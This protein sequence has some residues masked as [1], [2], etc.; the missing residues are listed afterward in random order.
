LSPQAVPGI[1][2]GTPMNFID[3]QETLRQLSRQNPAEA[4]NRQI[5]RSYE[6][7]H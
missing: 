3:A 4:Q 2:T 7:V 6:L 5:V 1:G